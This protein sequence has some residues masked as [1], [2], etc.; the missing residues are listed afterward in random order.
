M[1][2]FPASFPCL[3]PSSYPWS[4][5]IILSVSSFL[6]FLEKKRASL[7]R[8]CDKSFENVVTTQIDPCKGNPRQSWILDSTQRIPDFLSCIPD[9]KPSNSGFHNFHNDF[10][11]MCVWF[12]FGQPRA[13]TFQY[14]NVF[15]F[16]GSCVVHGVE[17]ARW[18]QSNAYFPRVR[19]KLK[20]MQICTKHV[21]L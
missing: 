15:L 8:K 4:I 10:S 1:R 21:S 13:V 5:L 7:Q 20:V 3:F 14:R 11:N 9:F 16:L 18:Q 12:Y 19:I 17:N 6:L 2:L